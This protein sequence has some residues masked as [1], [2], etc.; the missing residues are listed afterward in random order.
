MLGLNYNIIVDG[1]DHQ[2]LGLVF[3]YVDQDLV[4]IVLVHDTR[5]SLFLIEDTSGP[6]T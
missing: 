4:H 6:V 3:L 1:F 2:L 5:L